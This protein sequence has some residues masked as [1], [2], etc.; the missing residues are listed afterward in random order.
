MRRLQR[1]HRGP[2]ARAIGQPIVAAAD[3]EGPGLTVAMELR[4][5][6]VQWRGRAMARTVR[7][8]WCRA[9]HAASYDL[10]RCTGRCG[11][12][13][14][15]S[16]ASTGPNGAPNWNGEWVSRNDVCDVEASKGVDASLQLSE[17]SETW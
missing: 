11:S 10:R 4:P 3:G 14:G 9:Y 5:S 15:G 2:I 7:H 8:R 1:G 16:A 17:I 6:V 13:R 12:G